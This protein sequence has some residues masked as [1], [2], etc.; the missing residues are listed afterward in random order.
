MGDVV[1][2][3]ADDSYTDTRTDYQKNEVAVD[4]NA[5]FTGMSQAPWLRDITAPSP[6]F[7]HKA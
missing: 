5:A 4:Y 7:A 2:P 3:G 6:C 1:G